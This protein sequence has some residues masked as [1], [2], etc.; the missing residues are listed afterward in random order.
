MVLLDLLKQNCPQEPT[1]HW[2]PWMVKHF[3]GYLAL[4]MKKKIL[5][6]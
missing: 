2:A 4:V 3:Q 5:K 6:Y 1:S